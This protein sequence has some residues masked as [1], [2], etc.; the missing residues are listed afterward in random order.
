[1]SHETTRRGSRA[2]NDYE[3]NTCQKLERFPGN[4]VAIL[5]S[6]RSRT[7]PKFSGRLD[8]TRRDTT[9]RTAVTTRARERRV[10]IELA[11]RNAGTDSRKRYGE[12]EKRLRRA[13]ARHA[14][15]S[16]PSQSRSRPVSVSPATC[17]VVHRVRRLSL[18]L[19]IR[20]AVSLTRS[21]GDRAIL[22]RPH[23]PVL[24]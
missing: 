22:R 15:R 17:I 7:R 11:P 4:D 16:D 21:V 1:M 3:V 24:H 8:A 19:P 20:P 14:Y 2:R 9:H 12:T 23:C 13:H 5:F 6:H 18:S 10:Q